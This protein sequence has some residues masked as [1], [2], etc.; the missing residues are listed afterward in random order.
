MTTI[1]ERDVDRWTRVFST[2]KVY[3]EVFP[4]DDSLVMET[5]DKIN[6]SF[7]EYKLLQKKMNRVK[8][9]HNH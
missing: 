5:A 4:C 2:L 9:K 1:R 3:N 6:Q 7:E 8:S